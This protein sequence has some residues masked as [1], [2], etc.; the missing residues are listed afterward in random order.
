V[1]DLPVVN[2]RLA[3]FE[4]KLV[5]GRAADPRRQTHARRARRAR[6]RSGDRWIHGD[7]QLSHGHGPTVAPGSYHAT[8]RVGAARALSRPVV[9]LPRSPSERRPAARP[10]ES[11]SGAGAATAG[12]TMPAR[13]RAVL[14][15]RRI[16]SRRATRTLVRDFRRRRAPTTIS[17]RL[18]VA[19]GGRRSLR[20]HPTRDRSL[21]N[22]ASRG[23]VRRPVLRPGTQSRLADAA[24]T[25]QHD[26][27]AVAS[28][29]KSVEARDLGRSIQPVHLRTL[30][31]KTL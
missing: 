18:R 2:G 31:F 26:E 17:L 23:R 10:R 8:R 7:R 14:R 15:M 27:A 24:P 9:T 3:E 13:Q 29:R 21:P 11:T 22:A 30:C 28:C 16:P 6:C 19:S 1:F 5:C 20:Q 4:R 25:P 12:R